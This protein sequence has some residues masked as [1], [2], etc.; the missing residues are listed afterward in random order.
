VDKVVD[1]APVAC[2]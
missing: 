1:K 2:G